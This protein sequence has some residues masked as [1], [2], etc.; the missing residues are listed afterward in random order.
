MIKEESFENKIRMAEQYI[1]QARKCPLDYYDDYADVQ[2]VMSDLES[3][4]ITTE[5]LLNKFFNDKLE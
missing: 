1:V 4:R 3:V 2:R 5:S